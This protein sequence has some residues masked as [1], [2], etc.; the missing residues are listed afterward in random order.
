MF[1]VVTMLRHPQASSLPAS[2]AYAEQRIVPRYT[3]AAFAEVTDTATETCIRGRI[4]EISSKGCYID[5]LNT[6]PVGT[7]LD[8]YIFHDRGTFATKGKVLYVRE[9]I[10]MGVLF[11]DLPKDQSEG[12]DSWLDGLPL[13]DA[14]KT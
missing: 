3:V 2:T 9:Q 14:Q 7:P 6:L 13:Y 4:T 12:L 10:G 5:S 1:E 11:L 8:L